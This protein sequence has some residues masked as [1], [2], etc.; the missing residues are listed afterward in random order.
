MQQAT[1]DA[2]FRTQLEPLAPIIRPSAPATFAMASPPSASH[3]PSVVEE[4]VASNPTAVA[5]PLTSPVP[6]APAVAPAAPMEHLMTSAS[7]A[8]TAPPVPKRKK[9]QSKYQNVAVNLEKFE[10]EE[11]AAILD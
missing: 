6:V 9:S 1:L 8:S 5:E 10:L 3:T 7:T 11:C 4:I 2:R